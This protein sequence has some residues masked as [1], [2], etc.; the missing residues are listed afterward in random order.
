MHIDRVKKEHVFLI[1]SASGVIYL[2][3]YLLIHENTIKR[4]KVIPYKPLYREKRETAP[5][6]RIGGLLK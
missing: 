3:I 6:S 4:C 2:L 1:L 5:A